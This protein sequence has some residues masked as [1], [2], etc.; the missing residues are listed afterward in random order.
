MTLIAAALAVALAAADPTPTPLPDPCGSINSLVTRPTISTSPCTVRPHH[1]VMENGWS[2]TI[3]TGPGGGAATSFAQ[4]FIHFGTWDP[5]LEFSITPPSWNRATAGGTLIEGASDMNVG[6]KYELGYD[7]K[8]V[9]GINAQISIPS[10]DVGFSAGG[11]QYTGNFDW[12][13]QLD[14]ASSL[15]GTVSVNSLTAFDASGDLKRY[16]TVIPAVVL[17]EGISS[18]SQVFGEYAYFT[19]AGPTLGSKT[20]IDFGIVRVMTPNTQADVEY[21]FSPTIIA[22]QK[23]HFIGVGL[24]FMN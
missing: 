11:P 16:S 7:V 15:A 18:D 5:H 10:G 20:V 12:T 3:T 9:W 8:A 17:S 22:G 19:S 13:Y 6:A 14:D 2:N 24:S 4:T 1:V 23:Q 21:G